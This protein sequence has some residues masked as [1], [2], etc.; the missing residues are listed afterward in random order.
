MPPKQFHFIGDSITNG[1]ADSVSS[2]EQGGKGAYWELIAEWLAAIPSIGPLVSPGFRP[3]GASTVEWSQSSGWT[4]TVTTD[5]FDKAICG[6][7]S[8][9]S[10]STKTVTYTHP[11][12]WREAV[13]LEVDW[14]DYFDAGRSLQSG[15][16]SWQ[17]NGGA[18]NNMG[19]ALAHD[20]SYNR[21]YIATT[22]APGD[23]ITFR[24]ADASG[25]AA[26]CFITGIRPYFMAPSSDGL[27]VNNFGV[28]GQTLNNFSKATSGDRMA[29]LDNVKL[30]SGSPNNT[31][32]AIGAIGEFVNDMA[33]INNTTTWA[34]D[35]TDLHTRLVTNCPLAMMT[36]WELDLG[37]DTATVQAN[38]RAQTA[39]TCA[40]FSP[41]AQVYSI[42]DNWKARGLGDTGAQNALITAAGLVVVLLGNAVHESQLGHIDIAD[43]LFWF[44]RNTFFSAYP[45]K[46]LFAMGGKVAAPTTHKGKIAAPAAF[47]AG[48][49]VKIR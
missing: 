29:V 5:A 20:N 37:V 17:K 45:G 40:G 49:P 1:N 18:W 14:V 6:I 46:P 27:I 10:G 33:I 8:Y 44:I 36:T 13:G 24:A 42:F 7:G 28:G 4:S 48:R 31:I 43:Q 25:T 39:T 3:L 32:S 22:L 19:E 41:A 35:V 2:V 47:S 38:Y 11:T 30:G 12:R 34:T 15:N 26:G 21:F 9:A 16:W 23:T